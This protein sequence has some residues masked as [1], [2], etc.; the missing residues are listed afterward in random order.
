M[1]LNPGPAPERQGRGAGGRAPALAGPGVV[2]RQRA[3][4]VAQPLPRQRRERDGVLELHVEPLVAPEQDREDAEQS[5]EALLLL[6]AAGQLAGVAAR[7]DEP[8]VVDGDRDEE[9]VGRGAVEPGVHLH[10]DEA[11]LREQELAGAAPAAFH[12]ELL[13]K[14]VAQQVLGNAIDPDAE[15]GGVF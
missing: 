8:L 5:P 11:R 9:D 13:R 1:P 14:A 7:L 3:R 12:V 6:L 15:G 10:R 2:H 4:P